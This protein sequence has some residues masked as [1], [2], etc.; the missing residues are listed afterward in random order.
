MKIRLNTALLKQ[1]RIPKTET[2]GCLISEWINRKNLQS[3]VDMT[4]L[5][6]AA[7]TIGFEP[8]KSQSTFDSTLKEDSDNQSANYECIQ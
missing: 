7:K 5:T 1:P 2:Q 4:S 6:S 3:A 8:L